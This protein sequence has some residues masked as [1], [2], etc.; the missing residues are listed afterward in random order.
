[1]REISVEQIKKQ[2]AELCLK[3]AFD[4]PQDVRQALQQAAASE[5]SPLGKSLLGQCLENCR[6]ASESRIP[7]CQDTGT[8]VFFVDIG[9]DV[10]IVGGDLTEAL[11]HATE[12]AWKDG[13][14]RMS[15]AQ[16]PLFARKNTGTNCPPIIHLSLVPGDRLKIT[17]APKGG[18]SENMSRLAMLVPTAGA[19]AVADFIYETVALAGGSPCPPVIVGVGIGGNFETAPLMAKRA[20]LRPLGQPHPEAEYAEFEKKIL[21]RINESGIGPQ[22]L[23]GGSTALAVHIEHSPCHIASLPV[24][25]NLNCHAARHASAEI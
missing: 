18:G 1:M 25:V 11:A 24:A 16:D 14:L 22:G 3:A 23:G 6:I 4:L 12:A 9:Q 15:I 2:A 10:R 21:D 5:P 20:L 8:A 7:I 13:Y 19:E 17:V